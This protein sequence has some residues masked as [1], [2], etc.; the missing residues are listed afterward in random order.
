[1]W[2]RLQ[3]NFTAS[4]KCAEANSIK[5]TRLA[6]KVARV[7]FSQKVSRKTPTAGDKSF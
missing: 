4:P 3:A 7:E 1:M 6:P 2:L 5:V